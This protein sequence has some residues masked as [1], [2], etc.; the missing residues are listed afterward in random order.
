MIQGVAVVDGGKHGRRESQRRRGHSR[1]RLVP[2]EGPRAEESEG[3]DVA[4]WADEAGGEQHAFESVRS[5]DL[6]IR[7]KTRAL[8][9]TKLN[10]VCSRISLVPLA[11]CIVLDRSWEK[12]RSRL[13][14]SSCG[15]PTA[16]RG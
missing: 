11:V 3:E 13:G 2:L 16:G 1:D 8:C 7:V 14:S 15:S 9:K 5:S 4:P 12:R 10:S 6:P